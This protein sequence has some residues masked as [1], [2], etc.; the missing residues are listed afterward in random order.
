M[1]PSVGRIVHYVSRG[2]ADG[3]YPSRHVPLIVVE[4]WGDLISGWTHNPHGT[5]YE[6][7]VPHDESGAPA[8]WHW[9]EREE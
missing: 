8:S 6:E 7:H 5:R 1:K 9:P 4:C 3:E 2:S